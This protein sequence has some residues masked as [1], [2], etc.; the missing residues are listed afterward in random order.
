MSDVKYIYDTAY[1]LREVV[2]NLVNKKQGGGARIILKKIQ[3]YCSEKKNKKKG[4]KRIHMLSSIGPGRQKMKAGPNRE[5][6]RK[7]E[8]RL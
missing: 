4:T 3:V 8:D 6:E 5:K 7:K 2:V 1:Y